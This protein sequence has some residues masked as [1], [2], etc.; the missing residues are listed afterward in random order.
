MIKSAKNRAR[1]Y[2]ANQLSTS[3]A[4]RILGQCE[5]SSEFVAISGIGLRNV[6]NRVR[7]SRA[8][9]R[10]S[11]FRSQ[12]RPRCVRCSKPL[13]EK[14]IFHLQPRLPRAEHSQQLV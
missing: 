12:T 11:R 9:N 14:Q 4:R 3:E 1:R 13:V 10:W 8:N 2:F 5:M 6:A 7:Q